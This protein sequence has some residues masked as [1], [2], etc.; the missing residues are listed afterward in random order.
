MDGNA[1]ESVRG[2]YAQLESSQRV[3]ADGLDRYRF[4]DRVADAASK[5][6]QGKHDFVVP[7]TVSKIRLSPLAGR[8]KIE[9]GSLARMGFATKLSRS[10]LTQADELASP[11]SMLKSGILTDFRPEELENLRALFQMY[12]ETDTGRLGMEDLTVSEPVSRLFVLSDVRVDVEIARNA[13]I[14]FECG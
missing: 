2:F 13:W 8:K 12:D 9:L 14:F 4:E 10:T 7:E 5:I 11:L 3:I 1:D 6:F